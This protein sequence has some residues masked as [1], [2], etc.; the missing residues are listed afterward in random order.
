[1]K[2]HEIEIAPTALD[3][4][5]RIRDKKAR[6]EIA[7]L[8]DA[9]DRQPEAQ[10]KALSAPLD[11]L[12]SLRASRDRYRVLFRV[13]ERVVRVLL[14]GPRRPGK[15]TDVYAVARSLLKVVLGE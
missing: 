11:G 3:A 1:M 14:V 6:R 9:L 15:G 2:R 10:G 8:I 7:A 4:I 12:R 13:D 5:G